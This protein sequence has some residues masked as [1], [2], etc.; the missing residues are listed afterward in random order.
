M[1]GVEAELIT[2]MQFDGKCAVVR[3]ER[4]LVSPYVAFV[5]GRG[6]ESFFCTMYLGKDMEGLHNEVVG[7]VRKRGYSEV[8]SVREAAA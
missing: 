7:I 5:D 8:P 3:T 2:C 1:A 4:G 6:E